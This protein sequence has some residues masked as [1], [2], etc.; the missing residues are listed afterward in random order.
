MSN[1]SKNNKELNNKNEKMKTIIGIAMIVF[2]IAVAGGTFA[3]YQST[4]TGNVGATILAWDCANQ[5]GSLTGALGDLVPGSNG[6][7]ALKVKSSNFV[8]NITVDFFYNDSANVPPNLKLYKESAHTNVIPVS[9]LNPSSVTSGKYVKS[10]TGGLTTLSNWSYSNYIT[11]VGGRTYYFDEVNSSANVAGTAWYDA[12]KKYIS[13][14]NATA[15]ANAGNKYQAPANAKYMRHSFNANVNPDWANTVMIYEGTT[16]QT[17][18]LSATN[19]AANSVKT[20][21][22][23]YYWPRGTEVEEPI[24]TG[25]TNKELAIT[26]RITCQQA[27]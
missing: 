21:N 16:D 27:Q 14:F 3:Y 15:L 7:F 10:D 11:V 13:G 2:A 1:R 19:V 6:S 18:G 20:F 24:A 25:T 17:P 5:T 23:Y 22:V 8:T 9:L 26:Y 4:I 12:S